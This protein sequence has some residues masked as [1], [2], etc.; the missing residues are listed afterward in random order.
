MRLT[1]W[2]DYSLRVL[3]YCAEN[4]DRATPVTIT[5]IQELHGISRHH[6]SKVVMTLAALGYLQTTRGRGGG[7]RLLGDAQK[8]RVGD[9]VRKTET[10]FTLLECMDPAINTC[11]LNGR[12]ELKH[13]VQ[14]A[15]DSFL[16]VLDAVTLGDL[17]RPSARRAIVTMPS[18]GHRGTAGMRTPTRR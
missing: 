10:D 16:K 8:I 6:L 1:Q 12:C 14:T 11:F 2:T 3:L 18:P 7:L 13:V 17:I 9:V 15:T 4:L 5:E